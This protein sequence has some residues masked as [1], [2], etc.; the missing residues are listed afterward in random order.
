MISNKPAEL[1][2]RLMISMV[3][4]REILR[5]FI[6]LKFFSRRIKI[7]LKD[8]AQT[9]ETSKFIEKSVDFKA[10]FEAPLCLRLCV[11]PNL[12]LGLIQAL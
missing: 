10:Q 7:P 4:T 1:T 8:E 5:G 9:V 3:L 6:N 2:T 11:I 12:L